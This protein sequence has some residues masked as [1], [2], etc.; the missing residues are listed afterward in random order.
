MSRHIP[1]VYICARSPNST[2]YPPRTPAIIDWF[3]SGIAVLYQPCLDRS[4]ILADNFYILST[5]KYTAFLLAFFARLSALLQNEDLVQ[6]YKI[7]ECA[8]QQHY[9][10]LWDYFAEPLESSNLQLF[11]QHVLMD[12]EETMK[13]YTTPNRAMRYF[14]NAYTYQLR[15][16]YQTLVQSF[17]AVGYQGEITLVL[18][19][20]EARHLCE[21]SAADGSPIHEEYDVFRGDDQQKSDKNAISGNV[22]FFSVLC[23]QKSIAFL[24]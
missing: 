10:W 24:V 17:E 21:M 3:D 9:T 11:W 22:P 13:P 15:D 8:E 18:V 23:T 14:E 12:A 5:L 16:T 6:Q 4:T 2:G 20:D 7:R 19:C 1:L